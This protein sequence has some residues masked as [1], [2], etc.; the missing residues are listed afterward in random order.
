MS[1]VPWDQS[2]SARKFREYHQYVGIFAL[3]F[4]YHRQQHEVLQMRAEQQYYTTSNKKNLFLHTVR[5]EEV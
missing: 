5:T 3:K 1:I 4:T 2:S